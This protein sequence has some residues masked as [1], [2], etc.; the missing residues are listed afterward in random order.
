VAAV[1]AA[2]AASIV[3]AACG[4]GSGQAT[5]LLHETFTGRHQINSGNLHFSVSIAPSGPSAIGGPITL[6]LGGPFQSLG[7]GRLPE[8]DFNLSVGTSGGTVSVA[9]ISTGSKGYVTFQGQ[10]YQLPQATF[11]RLESSFAQIG[12]SPASRGGSGVL[13][14]L[15]IQPQHW[16]V[17]PQVLGDEALGGTNTTHIRAGINVLALLND[18]N[19]FL[20]RASSIGA[21]GP[22]SS[23]PTGISAAT[24]NRIAGEIHNPRLDV[25]TGTADKTLRRLQLQLTL[26]LSGQ[27]AGLL[28]RSTQV[29]VTMDYANLNQRQTISAPTATLPYSQFQAKL[30]VLLADLQGSVTGG[31]LGGAGAGTTGAGGAATNEQRYSQCIQA[32]NGDVAKMQKCAP[33]LGG[34]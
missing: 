7:S 9:M 23:F 20:K 18:L 12:S 33:L 8:S 28:G 24:R 34:R 17:G 30:K 13:A 26:G 16:L 5:K 29:A 10:S 32:A 15:G 25:W 6:S 27:L 21:A 22:S 3:L 11:Q 19:T 1:V 14:K 4:S 31:L 2:L